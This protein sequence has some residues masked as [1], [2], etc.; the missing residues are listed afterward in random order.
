MGQ[1]AGPGSNQVSSLS[2]WLDL[3]LSTPEE[4]WAGYDSEENPAENPSPALEEELGF[5]PTVAYRSN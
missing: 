3:W 1:P 4:Q 5:I 2:E